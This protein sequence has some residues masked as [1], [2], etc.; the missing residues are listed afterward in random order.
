MISKPIGVMKLGEAPEARRTA[1]VLGA[2]GDLTVHPVEVGGQGMFGRK[3]NLAQVAS[4]GQ[5]SPDD[6]LRSARPKGST[7]C[8]TE[9]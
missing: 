4:L 9:L 1:R 2:K 5:G 7:T 8:G 6:G 3:N